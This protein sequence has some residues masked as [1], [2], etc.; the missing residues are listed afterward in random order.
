MSGVFC[1]WTAAN[2]NGSKMQLNILIMH[3]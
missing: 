3:S 2:A 1:H